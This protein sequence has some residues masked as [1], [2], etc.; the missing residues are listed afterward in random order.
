MGRD[1]RVGSSTSAEI[2]VDAY[3]VTSAQAIASTSPTQI[4]FNAENL[5]LRSEFDISTGL[6]TAKV[7]G[8][9]YVTSHVSATSYTASERY[10]LIV[11]KNGAAICSHSEENSSGSGYGQ[12]AGCH[13]T[14]AV[15]DTL[16]VYSD[17]VADASYNIA[18][19]ADTSQLFITRTAL[20]SNTLLRGDT[21]DLSGWL[22][23]AGTA[24]CQWSTS[25]ASMAAFAADT[26]CPSQTVVGNVTAPGT[27]IP[28]MVVTNLLP[29]KYLIEARGSFLA[30]QSTSGNASCAYEIYD[31]T[32]SGTGAVLGDLV[33]AGRNYGNI[34]QGT[35]NYSSKQSSVTFQVRGKLITGNGTCDI[36]ANAAN[37]DFE[38]RI[39]PLSQSL[40]RPFIAS[41]V[42]AGRS[43][44]SKVG[45]ANI[46]C[47]AGSAIT[48][49][50]DS[51]ISTVGNIS[52]GACAI[53]FNTG[54]F[55]STPECFITMQN[56]SATMRS[57]T[58]HT[59]ST[60][61]VTTR[62]R[63]AASTTSATTVQD[64]TAIDFILM[65]IGNN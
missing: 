31:G 14:L 53:T 64:C 44:V 30:Q 27:K 57:M 65:C 5:D 6:F 24:N 34:V 28:G 11:Y 36:V 42:F 59:A 33:N 25:S 47:D 10:F 43:A 23:Y 16:A 15:G 18:A 3:R 21:S 56:N 13:A 12:I 51:M 39:I 55:S 41:S 8:E 17:S 49:N 2:V 48:T 35:F 46:N 58:Y 63:E 32:N 38:M 52:A 20:A 22:S 60:S 26:D 4:I 37:A 50:N 1:Y 7:A 62:C 45:V 40:P 29:G 61:G 19:G 9:Y 54:F